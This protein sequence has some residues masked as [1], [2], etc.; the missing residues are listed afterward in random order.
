LGPAPRD[1]P[2]VAKQEPVARGSANDPRA[3]GHHEQAEIS[4]TLTKLEAFTS[5]DEFMSNDK[6][7]EMFDDLLRRI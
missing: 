7:D 5:V 4:A 6:V 1:Q 3:E 2:A